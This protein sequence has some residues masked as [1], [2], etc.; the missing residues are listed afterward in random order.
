MYFRTLP[1]LSCA[2]VI[3]VGFTFAAD[4]PPTVILPTSVPYPPSDGIAPNG[5]GASS[6]MVFFTQPFVDGLQPRGVYTITVPGGAVSNV[7]TI[8]GSFPL[9]GVENSVTVVPS[10]AGSGFHP[11][12]I[13]T[14]G[15]SV[16][17]ACGVGT[18]DAVYKN[19]SSIPFIDCLVSPNSKHQIDVRFDLVG[20]FNGA[21]I[22]TDDSN[23]LLYNST[24][25][26]LASYTGNAGFVLQASTVA[27]LSYAAC[28]GCIFV[29]AMPAGNIDF[30]PPS[31]T[32]EILRVSPSAASGTPAVFFAATTGLPEPESIDF[33]TPESLS[34]TIGGFT[35]FASGYATGTQ[36]NRSTSTDGAILAWTPSQLLA[37]GAVGHFIVQNEEFGTSASGVVPG[38]IFI[39]GQFSNP[40]SDSTTT[41][42]QLEDTTLAQCKPATGCPATQGFWHKAN[43][44][45]TVSG[46]FAGVTW[47]ASTGKLSIG[48]QTYTQAQI[49]ELLPSGSLH[50]GGVE[51]DLSQFIAAA[52][53]VIAGAQQTLKINFILGT[54]AADLS[55]TNLFVPAATAPNI[56]AQ[57]AA[58]LAKYGGALDAYNSATGLGCSEGSG[59]STGSGS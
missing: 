27:P 34:C 47:N 38:G 17:G 15:A 18:F 54:I 41:K 31:G 43:H 53:N 1:V 52:L 6:S 9:P 59:L 32:G 14:T 8:P 12:D 56:P 20:S 33:I 39:D 37:A 44:W 11:G 45:P 40:F 35:L 28:P 16:S 21:M 2:V 23:I 10:P 58:D 13:Y 3:T 42:Y 25:A 36:I 48:A 55:G 51:N 7:N 50:T 30:F 24:P 49:L 26:L 57:A 46:S 19:G 5:I 29:T 22:V 4:Q